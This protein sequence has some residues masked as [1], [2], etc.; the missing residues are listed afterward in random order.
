[1]ER[2]RDEDDER[3]CFI[4]LG[5]QPFIHYSFTALCPALKIP[6]WTSSPGPCS[7]D[8]RLWEERMDSKPIKTV[9]GGHPAL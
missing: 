1:M 2:A 9:T 6:R 8:L 7:G 3:A 5:L 4:A